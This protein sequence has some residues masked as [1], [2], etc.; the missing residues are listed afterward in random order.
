MVGTGFA[1]FP[2]LVC[3]PVSSA[4]DKDC[5]LSGVTVLHLPE[6][7]IPHEQLYRECCDEACVPEHDW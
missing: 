4:P 1:F 2:V 5:W 6:D 7:G 3:V